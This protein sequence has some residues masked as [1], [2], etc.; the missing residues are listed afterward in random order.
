L[1]LNEHT[2]T[3]ARRTLKRLGVTHVLRPQTESPVTQPPLGAAQPDPLKVQTS[4]H[5]V[6]SQK[7][8]LAIKEPVLLRP[9][10]HGKQTPVRTLWTY[11]GLFGDMRAANNSPR[12]AFFSKIQES[13]CQH[14]K[15]EQKNLCSWPL[16]LDP[17]VFEIGMNHFKPRKIIFF[18]GHKTEIS[19]ESV[20]NQLFMERSECRII[21]L[22][23][24][25][26]MAQGNQQLKNEAWKLLQEIEG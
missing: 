7:P 14:L 19:Q 4:P 18:C 10:F 17:A 2:L 25:V 22:P 16:D 23:N 6:P 8:A 26:E 9:L 20:Q 1:D 11:A 21:R 15:W 24:L 13:V 12:L 5:N 3:E